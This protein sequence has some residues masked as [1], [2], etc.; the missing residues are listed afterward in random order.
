MVENKSNKY[1]CSVASFVEKQ[2]NVYE[3][4]DL[5]SNAAGS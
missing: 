4:L 5:R 2:N 3:G 1:C